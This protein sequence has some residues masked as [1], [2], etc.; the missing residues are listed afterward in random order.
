MLLV[1]RRDAFRLVALAIGI[2]VTM[3]L[4]GCAQIAASSAPLTQP[5]V[6]S[7]AGV[8][9]LAATLRAQDLSPRDDLALA[10]DLLAGG[11]PA[12][13]VIT[14]EDHI[15]RLGDAEHFFVSDAHT[16]VAREI[17][18]TLRLRG[19]HLEMWVEEGAS[20]A[21]DALGRS[22]GAFDTHIYPA[23]CEAF[24]TAP[25]LGVDGHPRLTVL[26]ADLTDIAGYYTSANEYPRSVNP[27]SNERPMVVMNLRA[28]LPGTDAYDAILAH[29]FQHLIHWSQDPNE[30]AWLNE[31]LSELA[32]VL[33]GYPEKS[34][35][36]ERF[37]ATP[38]LPLTQWAE[39]KGGLA[40]HYGAS[41]AFVRYLYDRFGPVFIRR[42]VAEPGNG[43]AGV[44]R[45]LASVSAGSDVDALLADWMLA[46]V[47]PAGDSAS[48]NVAYRDLAIGARPTPVTTYP[49]T[50]VDQVHQY[51]ADYIALEPYAGGTLTL[52]FA[53]QPTAPLLPAGAA[54][55]RYRWWSSRGDNSHTWLERTIDLTG[56]GTPL[57]TFRLWFDLEEGWDYAYLR[58]SSDGGATWTLLRGDH[59]SDVP[60]RGASFG[61]GYT[62]RSG[63]EE[64]PS[65]VTET[66]NLS[67]FAGHT[68]LLRF[69]VVTDDSV[70]GNGLC[71]DDLAIA[72]IRWHD[73]AEDGEEGWL[74]QGFVRGDNT[75]P[76]EYI[77]LLVTW[78]TEPAVRRLDVPADGSGTWQ[79]D[80]W[81]I[82]VQRALLAIMATA[83]KTSEQ[84]TY[85]LT[86]E[87]I[88]QPA[89]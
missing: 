11:T 13:S 84:A 24:G 77:V 70:N 36:L 65:W 18:A 44:D 39:G 75:L 69:D 25:S 74:A 5:P 81:G 58:V 17:T 32:E 19:T 62:G 60:P 78:G 27:T 9:P 2:G 21:Q 29:E 45:V 82:D 40:A 76:Q 83:P 68:V 22:A 35:R 6:P 42:L 71:L 34:P 33:A 8:P 66:V 26:N 54:S 49:T 61:P 67:P 1:R 89:E 16:G 10:R 72:E 37:A 86:L 28:A 57:L 79:V 63:G 64:V 46:N 7:V 55:G 56:A 50:L 87:E 3:A 30:D 12:P 73:D 4:D 15:P 85:T 43:L 52:A 80:G 53:G 20:V 48:V 47:L 38:D 41:Y 88:P 14:R 31:G 51:G 59:M 23:L